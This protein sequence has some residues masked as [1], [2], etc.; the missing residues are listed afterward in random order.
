MRS[1]AEQLKIAETLLAEIQH[2]RRAVPESLRRLIRDYFSDNQRGHATKI[3]PVCP[4][5]SQT[6]SS[7]E[8]CGG[9][10]HYA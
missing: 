1:Q 2:G 6:N 3:A 10:W 5:C 4:V 7:D 8:H 9:D